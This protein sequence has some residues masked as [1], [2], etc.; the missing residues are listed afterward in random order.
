MILQLSLKGDPVAIVVSRS[1]LVVAGSQDASALDAMARFVDA[2]MQKEARPISLLPIVYRNGDWQP[3]D[4]TDAI[5]ASLDQLRA[6]QHLW[7]YGEQKRLLEAHYEKQGRDV[8]VASLDALEYE[9]R[10]RTWTTWTYN[11]VSLLPEADVVILNPGEGRSMLVRSWSDIRDICGMLQPEPGTYPP[12]YLVEQGPR[13]EDWQRLAA[14]EHPSW[15]P[16][17]PAKKP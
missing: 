7:D 11:A 10:L 9:G 8:F 15:F 14:R 1:G 6:K 13:D 4:T 17:V 16:P 3:L 2:H 5:Y 12:R